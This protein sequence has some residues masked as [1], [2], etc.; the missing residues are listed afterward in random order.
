VPGEC[1]E[2]SP[3]LSEPQERWEQAKGKSDFLMDKK[4]F[5]NIWRSK[6]RKGACYVFQG[7]SAG[8]HVHHATQRFSRREKDVYVKMRDGV[9]LIPKRILITFYATR[10][11]NESIVYDIAST[12][13]NVRLIA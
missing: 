9:R 6:M 1:V 8:D 3:F 10:G 5:H 2:T 7:F 11:Q 12:W 4:P 13:L